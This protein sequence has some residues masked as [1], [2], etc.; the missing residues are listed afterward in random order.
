M[1]SNTASGAALAWPV[2]A[3]VSPRSLAGACPGIPRSLAGA[4]PGIPPYV[5]VDENTEL[6][7]F[8]PSQGIPNS[9]LPVVVQHGISR[10][11]GDAAGCERLF[12]ANGWGGSWRN[13]IFPFHHF[14]SNAHEAL[15][16]VSGVVTARLG[17]PDGQS[18]RLTA[19]RARTAGRG[20]GA[21]LALA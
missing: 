16:I 10:I 7:T 11:D 2:L 12:A 9:R 1:R 8:D 18:L 6:L 13:G 14:H 15:G 4:R 21:G 5:D 20:P 19:G 17:G 3:R